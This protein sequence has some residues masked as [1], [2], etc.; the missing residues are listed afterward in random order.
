MNM[1]TIPAMLAV[2]VTALALSGCFEE[3]EKVLDIVLTGETSAEFAQNETTSQWTEPAIIDMAEEIGDILEDNGYER[4]DLK[5]AHIMSVSYGV[6]SFDQAHDWSISGAITVADN[7][8]AQA[9][10]TYT[11][12]SVEEALNQKIPAPLQQ[13]GVDV[14][15]S[16]LDAFLDGQNPVLTFTIDNASTTPGP[17]VEDPMIFTWRAWLAIQVI[18]DEDVKVFDPF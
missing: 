10:V 11:S 1:K 14:I 18:I 7:G 4:D 6:T 8:P 3:E 13:G 17:T 9:I 5:S 12:Q 16:A 2:C 15:N